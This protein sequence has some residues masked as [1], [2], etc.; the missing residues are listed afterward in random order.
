[1]RTCRS[2]FLFLISWIFDLFEE[3]D[4]AAALAPPYLSPDLAPLAVARPVARIVTFGD[5]LR[6]ECKDIDATVGR[7]ANR[8]ER[9]R[10]V[11]SSS[12]PGHDVHA[13]P[14]TDR[15]GDF[16]RNRFV[17]AEARFRIS[18]LLH[19]VLPS[20]AGASN[21]SGAPLCPGCTSG[22]F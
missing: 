5:G 12:M 13:G 16:L 1:M 22:G 21:Y 19:I 15:L 10:E 6:P 3:N 2:R 9:Y 17:D 20:T 8:V 14:L 18:N 4:H 7:L 11:R